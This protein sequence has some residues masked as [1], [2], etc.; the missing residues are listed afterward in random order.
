MVPPWDPLRACA[1][2]DVERRL[3]HGLIRPSRAGPYACHWIFTNVCVTTVCRGEACLPCRPHILGFEPLDL[4]GV[5]GSATKCGAHLDLEAVY[6]PE[7]A[8]PHF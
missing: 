5:A 3:D 2:R 7:P 8:Y 1:H 4:P 6:S